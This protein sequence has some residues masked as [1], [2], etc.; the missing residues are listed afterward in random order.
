MSVCKD[1]S[2][3][4]RRYNGLLFKGYEIQRAETFIE[5]KFQ[6][7]RQIKRISIFRTANLKPAE[8]A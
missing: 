2:K 5:S 7:L 1:L 6:S 3:I 8:Q 4:E